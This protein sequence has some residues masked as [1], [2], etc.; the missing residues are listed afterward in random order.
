MNF[1]RIVPLMM[2]AA[3]TL[4]LT[5]CSSADPTPSAS[6]AAGVA[7]QVSL[8]T[9][10]TIATENRVSGQVVSDSQTMIMVGTTAKCT[11]VYAEA[12][13]EVKAGDAICKLDMASMQANY[14]AALISY[15]STVKS[16]E[17]QKAI[18]DTQLAQTEKQV[19]DLKA[20]FAI[21]AAAQNDVNSAELG[22]MQLQA[23]RDSALAQLEAGMQSGKSSLEQ[24]KQVL[25]DVDSAGNVIAPVSGTLVSMTATENG[26]VSA[27][28]PVA[29]ID[30][31]EQR[32]VSVMVSEALVNKLAIGDEAAVTVSAAEQSVTGVITAVD[33]SPNYQT[34]LYT[35]TLALP[36]G[37]GNLLAGMFADVTF[38]T[39]YSADTVVV[40][41]EA[42]L[43]SSGISYVFVVEEDTAR[44]VDVTTGLTGNGVTE[45]TSGLSVGQ[46]LVVVGQAYLED[47]AA[48]RIVEG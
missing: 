28:S 15:N 9:S 6:T 20:L 11:A 34:K 37:T 13:D 18:L 35:V 7:V 24:L 30:G 10:D 21:G 4:S 32:K 5:A 48:V 17:D 42:I 3:L 8:V 46:Q 38:H 22:L 19:E 47:G 1:K 31:N 16:Y 12:G 33:R 29:I 36:E 44:R 26:Y 27:S 23:S 39:D 2:A 41:S 45:I 43:T 14:N 25:E 40:P